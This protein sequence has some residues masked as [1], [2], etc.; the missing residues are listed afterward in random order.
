MLASATVVVAILLLQ[1]TILKPLFAWPS[2]YSASQMK[3][4]NDKENYFAPL[5]ITERESAMAC[6][7]NTADYYFS[8]SYFHLNNS[9][10]YDIGSSETICNNDCAASCGRHQLP[11]RICMPNI[12][13]TRTG[14]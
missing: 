14:I 10:S 3:L 2:E 1:D 13:S 4:P 11:L 12:I 9:V 5:T 7:K 8:R 6:Q